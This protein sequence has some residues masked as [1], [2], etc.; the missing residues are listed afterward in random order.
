[1]DVQLKYLP[2]L[3]YNQGLILNQ[4]WYVILWVSWVVKQMRY[5]DFLQFRR[6]FQ[7]VCCFLKDELWVQICSPDNEW[8]LLEIIG[9]LPVYKRNCLWSSCSCLS[10]STLSMSP[11]LFQGHPLHFNSITFLILIYYIEHMCCQF[12]KQF[13]KFIGK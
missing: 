5:W 2:Y 13:F 7:N 1:M 10:T 11:L 6:K 12:V 4:Q 9:C 3:Q 8:N